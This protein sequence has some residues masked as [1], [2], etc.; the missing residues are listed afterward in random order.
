MGKNFYIITAITVVVIL[1]VTGFIFKD[2]L[3]GN[4]EQRVIPVIS[5]LSDNEFT[6]KADH[7]DSMGIHPGTS[8]TLTTKNKVEKTSIE[9]NLVVEPKFKY[10]IESSD[11]N[12][13]SIVPEETLKDDTIYKF[14]IVAQQAGD[15]NVKDYQWA[16]QTKS[17]FKV[18]GTLPADQ[19]NYVPSTSGIEINF[20][21]ENYEDYEDYFSISPAVNGSFE[22]HRKTLVFVPDGL[23]K[24]TLYTVTI[25]SGL[26]LAGTDLIL[27]EDY[28]F[29]FETESDDYEVGNILFDDRFF[30]YPTDQAPILT[31][32][33]YN[34]GLSSIN[35]EVYGFD[36]FD[37]FTTAVDTLNSYPYWAYYSQQ[38][39]IYPTDALD[40]IINFDADIQ[41]QDYTKYIEFP[42]SL[43]FG[44]Y[45]VQIEYE[46]R[47][48]QAYLQ[49][50]D[51]IA[52][53]Q[54]TADNSFI[55][56]HD[57]STSEPLNN[58][59]ID[60][61]HD[62]SFHANTNGKGLAEFITPSQITIDEGDQ[63][64][65]V[66]YFIVEYNKQ[67]LLIPVEYYYE[68][69]SWMSGG[70]A[71][72]DYW[73]YLYT[74]RTLYSPTDSIKFWGVVK[75]R[76]GSQVTQ[77][78]AEL[79]TAPSYYYNMEETVLQSAN[80]DI[81][82]YGTFEGNFDYTNLSSGSYYLRISVGDKQ[83]QDKYIN[84][85]NY[86]KPSYKIEVATDKKAYF[87]GEDV[88]YNARTVYYDGTPLGNMELEYNS[89]LGNG[90]VTTNANGEVTI[91]IATSYS[92]SEYYPRSSYFSIRPT[93]AEI[94]DIYTE[95]NIYFFGPSID[96]EANMDENDVIEGNVFE[97]DL[98]TIN[99]EGSDYA[100]DFEGGPVPGVV[101]NSNVYHEYY[102]KTETGTRYDFINKKTYK[103]YDYNFN[104]DLVGTVEAIT[105]AEGKFVV[106]YN[107]EEGKKYKIELNITDSGG[108]T[109]TTNVYKYSGYFGYDYSGAQG[110]DS[111]NLLT[112]DGSAE[113]YTNI[114]QPG[115][116]V[117]I[118]FYKNEDLIPDT[119]NE[120]F[121]YF[122]GMT[123]VFDIVASDQ[124]NYSFDFE[125]SYAPNIYMYGIFFDGRSYHLTQALR[126]D[127]DTSIQALNIDIE[128]DQ[129]NYEPGE[130]VNLDITVT[131]AD[132][133]PVKAEVNISAIDEALTAIQW[134]NSAN[135]LNS[136][137][138]KLPYTLQFAYQSHKELLAPGAEGGGCFTGDT[139]IMMSDGSYKKISEI[140]VG[141]QVLT[142]QSEESATLV[143]GKVL[144][145][146]KHLVNGYL[147]INGDL[148]VTPEHVIYLNGEWKTAGQA[149]VGDYLINSV[150]EKVLIK[151]I[152]KSLQ[153]SLVYNLHIENYNTFLADDIYVHNN[154]G[155]DR[156]DFQDIA[157]FGSV[158]T[159]GNGQASISFNLPD[160][161]TSWLTTFHALSKNLQASSTQ[162]AV[163]ATLPFFV[164]VAMAEDYVV[165]DMPV[166]KIRAFG[167]GLDT[168]AQ[169]E[170][171][172]TYPEYS[173]EET[174]VNAN[175]TDPVEVALPEFTAGEYS[176]RVQGNQ[177]DNEDA[178]IKNFTFHDSNILDSS[179]GY[180]TVTE[181]LDIAGSEDGYTDLTF[182]NK[183]RGQYYNL[184]RRLS[185]SY[186]DRVEPKVS[187]YYSDKFMMDYFDVEMDGDS[188]FDFS[189]FQ[190]TD[191]GIS[192]LPYSSSDILLTA[193]T[194]EVASDKFDSESAIQYFNNILFN[195]DSNLDEIV[196]S[197]F[198]LANMGEPV[199][200]E[201]NI[202]METNVITPQLKIYLA[203]ALSNLGATEYAT[204]LLQEILDEYGS[205]VEPYIKLELGEYQDEYTEYSYQAAI[206]LAQAS[207]DKA[208]KLFNY[209]YDNLAT[210]QLNNLE[211][212]AYVQYALPLLSGDP[213]SFTYT[214][215]GDS[216]DISLQNNEKHSLKLTQ[217]QLDNITYS[218]I[219]GSVGV[220]SSYQVP[221]QLADLDVDADVSITRQYSVDGVPT[222]NFNEN[223][224]V[225]ITLT[226]NISTTAIDNDYQLT[227]YLP[228]GLKIL[229]NL[230]SRY[231]GYDNETR[232]PYEVDSQAVK[233]WT[234]E[235]TEPF[236]YYAIVINKGDFVAESPILQGF[237]VK[238]SINYGV[239]SA[240]NIE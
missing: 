238:D 152:E 22:K 237:K 119:T 144:N 52:S 74:N 92:D 44:Y 124:S 24:N 136:L 4:N 175:A 142:R 192:L 179:V 1:G 55:W 240:I 194:M 26:P 32:R 76:S 21:H 239:Q 233:F 204:V 135:F 63:I 151:S 85:S 86:T 89:D 20:S 162:T 155:G 78:K 120:D 168:N 15:D 84:I 58:A 67:Q 66:F 98:T 87:E 129:E 105:D 111:Y 158:E 208:E 211:Q 33:E 107:Y 196:Y 215:D 88:T 147:I 143:S 212:L 219:V 50:S 218:S 45:L 131:D 150:G 132:D 230:R 2:Q 11:N 134:D 99:D 116:T 133:N 53:F 43:A 187:R 28:V 40:L 200:T 161:V 159:A 23:A 209:A 228:S 103:T 210:D 69:C 165:G 190:Q 64:T 138:T 216:K 148:Q 30:E 207:S 232:Y 95:A 38:K 188:N 29:Q 91:S 16:Y 27:D 117:E 110:Y 235:N 49:V 104:S 166:V 65:N 54:G 3:F 224:I 51:F 236:H 31:V 176:I 41:E 185:W 125:D 82:S 18:M 6:L 34:S 137:Y 198:G 201:I 115:E 36:S 102:T 229:T 37:D 60:F 164:D 197:L 157:Y 154:K 83:I 79:L 42:E 7:Y 9:G 100:W 193:K 173:D 48:S 217:D 160:N 121:V 68:Y 73:T 221:M 35:V 127:Y 203:R 112:D 62:E 77:V 101:V 90:T 231:I 46:D 170:Y 14:S 8:F 17:T 177:G 12:E 145:T 169:V 227:D 184:L 199:L 205:T 70:N 57:L 39:N 223:D 220:I 156:T 122:K 226:P 114:F 183:E 195:M 213:V 234:N 61:S 141:D 140:R 128:Q 206:L 225:K 181:D 180:Y 93:Q 59:K 96:L 108:R 97:V 94:T 109:A 139:E 81:G 113:D 130:E 171:N 72:R 56:T 222:V 182:M 106:N 149:K 80:I 202:L 118:S 167:T 126:L 10:K 75:N 186:G 214:L 189:V 19:A 172:I 25:S 47:V 163:I 191:G 174:T 146:H 123:G 13:F 153:P 178:I 71:S 5:T